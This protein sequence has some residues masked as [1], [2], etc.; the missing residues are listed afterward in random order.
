MKQELVPVELIDP[1]PYKRLEFRDEAKVL[2]LAENIEQN[3]RDGVG[4][5]GLLEIPIARRVD[6]RYQLAFAYHRH[7]AFLHLAGQ[8][9]NEFSRMPLIIE[10]LTD[11]QM[12]EAMATE[13]LLHREVT[14]IEEAETF[15]QYMQLFH[16]T[17]AETATRYGK[18][19]EYVRSRLMFIQLP[20]SAK[21]RA[22]SGELN[23]SSARVL[24]SAQK[25]GGEKLVE[26]ALK[27][28]DTMKTSRMHD[29]P[30]DAIEHAIHN[31]PGVVRI[32]SSTPW[33]TANKNFPR[34]HLPK[35]TEKDLIS[36]LGVSSDSESR[37]AKEILDTLSHGEEFTSDDAT[38]PSFRPENLAKLRTL[39]NPPACDRCPFHTVVDGSQYCG[40][41]LCMERKKA[42]WS[43]KELEDIS[44]KLGVPLYQK[45]D[46]TMVQLSSFQEADQKLWNEGVADL[47]LVP[48]QYMY[49]NF[50]GVGQNLRVVVV[51][52]TAEKRL[53]ANATAQGKIDTE[54]VSRELQEK[55]NHTIA[56]FELRFGWEVVSNAL[57]PMLDGLA[58]PVLDYMMTQVFE[59][60]F[61]DVQLPQGSDDLDELIEQ[62]RGAKKAESAL[63]LRRILAYCL[64]FDRYIDVYGL[65]RENSIVEMAKRL[66]ETAKKWEVKLPK[67]FLKQAEK[68][69]AELD[70]AVRALKQPDEGKPAA[71]KAKK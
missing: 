4:T 20:D 15:H 51:G 52:A 22:R 27:E 32:Y 18:T 8:G 1:N 41:Q 5:I 29:T 38:Y 3:C 68:Y 53:K 23:V 31:A 26:K 69:Q 63:Q 58:A 40:I 44:K 64:I 10:S 49:N 36:V 13:I 30:Q 67:D 11:Q 50:D 66:Q 48:A 43:Q 65:N 17:S 62:A 9:K 35:L 61:D 45:S 59:Y 56:Q 19:D 2:E 55:V 37:L 21:E 34:K 7:Q 16:K 54:R 70:A 14:F 47:R 24:V 25:I 39:I 33:L 60:T 71:K 28:I 42:A 57:V 12:F 6:D 46:G